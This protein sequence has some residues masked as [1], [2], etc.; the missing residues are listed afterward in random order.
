MLGLVEQV[1]ATLDVVE[2]QLPKAFPDRIWT[3]IADGMR[4]QTK[5][6]QAEAGAIS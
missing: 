1:D 5:K 6:F 4:S 3:P 2:A